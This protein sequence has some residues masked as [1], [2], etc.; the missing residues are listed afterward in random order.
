[1]PAVP[2]CSSITTAI[3]ACARCIVASTSSSEAVSGTT[4]I[5]R[6]SPRATARSFDEPPQQILDVQH[7]DDVIEVA[8]VDRIARVAMLAENARESRRPARRPECRRRGRAAP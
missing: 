7:A 8:L 5:G 1:M 3:C 2:P 6:T 4:G